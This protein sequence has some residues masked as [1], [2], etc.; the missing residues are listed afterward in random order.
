MRVAAVGANELTRMLYFSPSMAQ[1][2]GELQLFV[3]KHEQQR[4]RAEKNE[5]GQGRK[6]H[7]EKGRG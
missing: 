3:T 5:L 4:E 6:A 7:P 2:L 1:W